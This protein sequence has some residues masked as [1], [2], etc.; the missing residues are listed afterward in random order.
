LGTAALSGVVR[1]SVTNTP[2][3]ARLQ[4]RRHG[5]SQPRASTD[6][7]PDGTYSVALLEGTYDVTLFP[8][9]PHPETAR[10]GI[11]HTFLGTQTDFVIAP[12]PVVL[13]ED[14]DGGPAGEVM[15]DL[16]TS[17]NVTFSVWNIAARNATVPADRIQLLAEPAILLWATGETTTNVLTAA[18]RA[19]ILGH[20]NRGKALI[21][22]GD[23]VAQTSPANDSLM[24]IYLGVEFVANLTDNSVR[25]FAGDPIGQGITTAAVGPSKDHLR[26]SA[27]AQSEVNKVFYYGT[28]L[29]DTARIGAVRAQHATADWRAVYFSFRLETSGVLRRRTI[30]GRSIDWLRETQ[31]VTVTER[32]ASNPPADFYLEQNYPNP[33]NPS[34][35]ITFGLPK[36]AVVNLAV[37]DL[38]GREVKT[39]VNGM[40]GAGRHQMVL[41]ANDLTAGIYVYRLRAG[42]F[43]ATRKLVVLK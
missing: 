16:L 3:Q 40:K 2:V 26:L 4:F 37:L 29:A 7:N 32:M 10:R 14:D 13:V 25:G 27:L 20:L 23:N 22:T 36:A 5:E 38:L 8:E 34:T 28:T 15:R 11:E 33:F 17:L 6:T 35:T 43:V 39:L 21:L 18:D 41:E 42:D 31:P 24:S 30:L 9:I 12:A 1:D 19:V